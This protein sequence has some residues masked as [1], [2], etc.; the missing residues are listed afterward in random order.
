M[1]K[2][3]IHCI[4]VVFILVTF[5]HVHAKNNYEEFS[6]MDMTEK[7]SQLR[8]RICVP[9]S[10]QCIKVKFNNDSIVYKKLKIAKPV[11]MNNVCLFK[12]D[13]D[14]KI[15]DVVSCIDY[16]KYIELLDKNKKYDVNT[17][18]PIVYREDVISNK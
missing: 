8:M 9:E 6:I 17:V 10:D 5:T 12:V 11:P 13:K 7:K 16:E 2:L 3:F 14:N 4:Y 15:T 1:R 18:Y